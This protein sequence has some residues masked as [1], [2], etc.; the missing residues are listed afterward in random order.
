MSEYVVEV[1]PL[2]L[3]VDININ[4]NVHNIYVC[5]NIRNGLY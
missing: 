3:E 2:V 5:V 1:R 4:M